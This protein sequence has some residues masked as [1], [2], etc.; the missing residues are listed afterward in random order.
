[1]SKIFPENDFYVVVTRNNGIRTFHICKNKNVYN[2][3]KKKC[4]PIAKHKLEVTSDGFLYI[5]NELSDIYTKVGTYFDFLK[6]CMIG[7]ITFESTNVLNEYIQNTNQMK[8]AT[9]EEIE[10]MLI[11]GG[12]TIYKSDKA[13]WVFCANNLKS[14]F[15]FLSTKQICLNQSEDIV[16]IYEQL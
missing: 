15:W 4:R 12:Y 8:N 5:R 14:S 9:I 6:W 11:A 2:K 13:V 1:M 3:L 16:E 10:T 7:I